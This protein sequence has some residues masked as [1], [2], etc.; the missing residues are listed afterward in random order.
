MKIKTEKET[1]R[2]TFWRLLLFVYI[3]SLIVYIAPVCN[4]Y[5]MLS[6]NRSN[7]PPLHFF[8]SIVVFLSTRLSLC[9]NSKNNMYSMPRN[10]QN[11]LHMTVPPPKKINNGI[12]CALVIQL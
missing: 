4:H 9:R 12:L 5:L 3:N 11:H 8:S 2:E 1:G 10:T 6:C 7:F